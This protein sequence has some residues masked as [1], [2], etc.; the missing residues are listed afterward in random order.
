MS[1]A[2]YAVT[3]SVRNSAAG[4]GAYA[5]SNGDTTAPDTSSFTVTTLV[6]ANG[7]ASDLQFINAIVVG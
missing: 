1:S 2:N 6:N 7:T 4:A 3:F 5:I